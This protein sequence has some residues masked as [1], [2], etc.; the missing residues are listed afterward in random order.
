MNIKEVK[1]T[2][3]DLQK[4]ADKGFGYFMKNIGMVLLMLLSV[5]IIT[6][7]TMITNPSEFFAGF[8][9]N[10]LWV[11]LVLFFALGGFYQLAKG[12]NEDNKKERDRENIEEYIEALDKRKEEAEQKHNELVK[13]RFKVGPHVSNELKNL[14]INLDADRAAILEMHNGTN[15]ISGLPFVYG[16]MVYEEISPNVNYASDEF[17]NFNLAKLPFVSLH[18]DDK[19]WIGS[20]DDIEQE[21]PYLAAKLRVVE[22]NYGAFVIL[23]GI[24]GPLGF[25][26]LFFKDEKKHPSKAKIIAELNHSSQILST[27]L[28]KYKE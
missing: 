24:N 21:D 7:P 13:E 12:V 11:V 5:Y 26:T 19:T 17:K 16:D 28:N 6:N 9:V 15:N 1:E 14:L 23:E 10:S 20:V 4:V 22:V 3:K 25:L 18:Y 8:N 2:K 27:L